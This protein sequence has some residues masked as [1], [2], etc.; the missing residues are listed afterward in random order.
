MAVMAG[1]DGVISIGSAAIGYID[2]WNLTLNRGTAEVSSIGRDYKEFIGTV[3]DFSGSAS[4]SF[5]YGDT[6][7]KSLVDSL[8][9][10]GSAAAVTMTLV[11]NSALTFSVSVILTSVALGAAHGDKITVSFNFQGTGDISAAS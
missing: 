7:Q 5:D 3:K 4:G 2:T 8:L 11:A 6:Q 10:G 9:T 1:K